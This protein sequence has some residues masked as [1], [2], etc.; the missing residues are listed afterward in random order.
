MKLPK[1]CKAE[2]YQYEFLICLAMGQGK[3]EGN[4][5]FP[6]LSYSHSPFHITS[7]DDGAT[8]TVLTLSRVYYF[9]VLLMPRI[10][11]FL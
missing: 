6:S 2:H 5:L 9:P 7:C 8:V 1:P 11:D 3:S 10:W 4:Y